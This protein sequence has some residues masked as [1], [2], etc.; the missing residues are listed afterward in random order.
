MTSIVKKNPLLSTLYY[1]CNFYDF[2]QKYL[3]I[4]N[5][6]NESWKF[7]DIPNEMKG[8]LQP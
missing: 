8:G 4:Y 6:I 1:L 5:F 2:I 7:C 3:Y